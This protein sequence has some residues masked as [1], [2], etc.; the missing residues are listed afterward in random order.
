MFE[1]IFNNT[2][3]GNTLY[4]WSYA[5]IIIFLVLIIGKILYWITKNILKKITKK[6][7]TNLDDIIIDMIEEPLILGLTLFGIWYALNTLNLTETTISIINKGYLFIIYLNLG[8]LI[9]R[10]FDSLYIEYIIP[11][12]K[13]TDQSLVDQILP[14]IRKGIKSIVWILAILVALNNAGYNI[15]A[16]LAGLGIGGIAL[17]MAAKDTISNIFGGVTIFTDQPFKIKDRIKIKGYDGTVTEIGI[18]S[19]R[20]KTL[21]GRIVTI[22]NSKFSE[23]EIENISSEPSRRVLLNL[24]LTYDT[25]PKKIE[26]AML[27]LKEIA[28]K[29]PNVNEKVLISFNSFNDFSLN[30]LFIYYIKKGADILKTQTQINSKILTHFNKNKLEFAFPTQTIHTTK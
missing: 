21:E 5:L 29:N 28:K 12:A 8:W 19:T 27:I 18:R 9:T 17:A 3:Y 6:T 16:I 22:P 13:K 30:I 1:N 20:I 7:K 4:E 26:L 14:I 10:L 23:S 25:T 11:F 15:G 24:G 2:Y